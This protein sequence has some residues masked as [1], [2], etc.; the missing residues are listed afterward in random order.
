ML[1]FHL[2]RLYNFYYIK[3]FGVK[4]GR[5]KETVRDVCEGKSFNNKKLIIDDTR[6]L[7]QKW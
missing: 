5:H 1:K 2:N 3:V 4:A 6:M 7:W